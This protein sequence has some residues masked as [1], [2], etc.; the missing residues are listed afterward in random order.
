MPEEDPRFGGIERLYGRAGRQRLA[1][2]HVA[3]VG[4]GGV[5]SWTVEALARTGVGRLTLIDLDDICITNT[6]RQLHAVEGQVGRAKVEAMAARVALIHP[7]CL[8][9]PVAAFFT[10]RTADTL[11]APGFDCVVDAIDHPRNKALLLSRC[12]GAG[13]PVVTVGGAGGRRDPASVMRGDLAA[14]VQDGLLREVR[15]L[16]RREHGF[17]E[18]GPWG[19]PAVFSR[20]RPVFPGADGTICEVPKDKSLRLDC[21]SG[22]GTAAFVTGTFGF[23]AAAAAVEALIG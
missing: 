13:V 19:I 6:N 22:F 10:E 15:R 3:V 18:E 21:A 5:G 14:S 1:A 16:L 23:A 17:P 12:Q 7:G 2:A 8:V 4:I 9:R 20:E 11:L